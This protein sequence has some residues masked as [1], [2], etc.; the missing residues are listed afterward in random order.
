MK[1]DI[2]RAGFAQSSQSIFGDRRGSLQ[3][4]ETQVAICAQRTRLAGQDAKGATPQ[5]P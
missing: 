3:L 1:V 4:L 2:Q 5:R